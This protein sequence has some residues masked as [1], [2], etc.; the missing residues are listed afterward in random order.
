MEWW[1]S[2]W[3]ADYTLR[4]VALGALILGATAG[5][6]GA[7]AVLRRQSLLGDAVS[8]TALPG[9]ALAFLLTGSKAPMVLLIGAAL[10]GWA[11]T[12]VIIGIV[13]TTR[14]KYDT[15]LG[16]TLSVFFGLGLVLLSLIQKR[17]DARQAGLDKFLFGQASAVLAEDVRVMALFGAAALAVV[18]LLW[19]EFK[20]LAF[21]PDYAQVQGFRV[22]A[23][24]VALTTVLV[25]GIV[26][27]LQM[28]GVVLMSAMVVAPAVA[29]RQWT[30]RF[31]VM[32]LLSGLFGALAGVGGATASSLA[33]RVPTGPAIVLCV[34]VL[35]AV[36]LLFAPRRGLLWNRIAQRRRDRRFQE[37]ATLLDLYT[38]ARQHPDAVHAHDVGVV[39]AMSVEPAG[40]RRALRALRAD[41]LVARDPAGRWH[42]TAAGYVRA[43]QVLRERG[44]EVAD[45]RA[46]D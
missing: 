11:A 44:R 14:V 15:A 2:S 33:L 21:D 10:A 24:D 13:R 3:F 36:S 4:T 8:H 43:E 18:L 23:I 12:L 17:P 45:D 34:G 16:L 26:L 22:A 19:K 35:V 32:I 25:I 30:D 5:A 31:G 6:L 27:G 42:L 20:L 39:R 29:A 7:L 46:A 40:T 1:S 41:G 9:I 28:V 38:L 37:Q